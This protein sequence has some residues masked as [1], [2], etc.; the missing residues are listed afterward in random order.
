MSVQFSIN[1]STLQLSNL[2]FPFTVNSF[3]RPYQVNTISSIVEYQNLTNG[4]D[5]LII[6]RKVFDTYPLSKTCNCPAF[7]I[8]ASEENKNMSTVLNIIDFFIDNQVSKG[9]KVIAVGGGIVQDLCACACSLFR[10][11]QPFVY[12]PTTTLGQLDSC[13]GAKCA[14]NT[15]KAKNILG[16]FSAP[17]EVVI[18]TLFIRSMPLI[19]HRAGLSEMLRLCLTASLDS[20]ESYLNFFPSIA[21]PR[22]IDLSIYTEALSLSLS[23]KKVVVDFDEYERDVRR[24][25]NYGHTFGHSIEKLTD[26]SLPHGIAVLLGMHM[27]NNFAMKI[28]LLP[29]KVYRSISNAVRMTIKDV[30][31][32]IK[33]LQILDP[34]NILDQF[35]FDKKGDGKSVPLILLKAPGEMVFHRYFFDSSANELVNSVQESLEE[36]LIWAQP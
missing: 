30:P 32:N 21:D 35:R 31:I 2:Q 14:V 7:Y 25:M 28:G 4:A 11:G 9:S 15:S 1:N 34:H 5:L 6:D 22:H 18:P 8:D 10:R 29:K 36:F 27:A 17:S 23:I 19:D 16:L 12:L 3:P 26:F 24:S 33:S 13:V 20:L